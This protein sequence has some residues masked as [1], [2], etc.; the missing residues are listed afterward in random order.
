MVSNQDVT[1]MIVVRGDTAK[2][3]CFLTP[4]VKNVNW[5]SENIGLISENWRI[6]PKTRR[7]QIEQNKTRD[8]TLVIKNVQFSDNGLYSCSCLGQSKYELKVNLTIINEPMSTTIRIAETTSVKRTA[9]SDVFGST[10]ASTPEIRKGSTQKEQPENRQFASGAC[11]NSHIT[12]VIML[13]LLP[14]INAYQSRVI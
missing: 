7:Y 5:T 3:P 10:S 11:K 1:S 4:D 12:A 9:S 6:L 13:M 14:G 8:W 2:L